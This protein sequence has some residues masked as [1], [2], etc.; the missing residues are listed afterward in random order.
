[1]ATT[2]ETLQ[3]FIDGEL[4]GGEGETEPVLNPAT[5]EE[6]ARAPRAAGLVAGHAPAA[7]GSAACDRGGARGARRGVRAP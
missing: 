5:G 3:N 7:L 1:M 2:V 6:M 4:V